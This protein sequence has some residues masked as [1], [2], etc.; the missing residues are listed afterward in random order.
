MLAAPFAS[1]ANTLCAPNNPKA[2]TA[3]LGLAA[4]AIDAGTKNRT[5]ASNSRVPT[6]ISLNMFMV[7]SPAQN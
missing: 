2:R 3:T 7:V 4:A 6:L 1:L 5:A